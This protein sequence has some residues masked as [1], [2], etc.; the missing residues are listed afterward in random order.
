MRQVRDVKQQFGLEFFGSRGHFLVQSG[1]FF[2]DAPDFSSC[3]A[4]DSFFDLR[5]PISLLN[6]FRSA[7]NC[8]T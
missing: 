2:T 7:F 6:R 5:I 1:N 8:C 3:S 4:L